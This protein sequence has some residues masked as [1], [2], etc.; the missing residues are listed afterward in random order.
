MTPELW[1]RAEKLFHAALEQGP[2]ARQTF[3]D[4]ACGEDA[5]LRRQVDLLVVAHEEAGSFFD[6]VGASDLSETAADGLL[7]G[8]EF[9]HYRIMSRLGEGGMGQ[10]ELSAA[11]NKSHHRRPAQSQQERQIANTAE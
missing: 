9:G 10:V 1:Y 11:R 4:T 8:R 3:L 6:Q 5:E 7:V 2:A